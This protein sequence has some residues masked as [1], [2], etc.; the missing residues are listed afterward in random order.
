MATSFTYIYHDGD[1]NHVLVT[2]F[3]LTLDKLKN[4]KKIREIF[5]Q[6]GKFKKFLKS[7]TEKSVK[8]RSEIMILIYMAIL[9][10]LFPDKVLL[11]INSTLRKTCLSPYSFS[12]MT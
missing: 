7:Q 9:K 11:K 10:K 1:K 6:S 8:I 5:F 12:L 4:M 3:P 2:R